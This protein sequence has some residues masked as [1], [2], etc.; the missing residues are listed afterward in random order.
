M[1]QIEQAVSAID[2]TTQQN[3]ALVEAVASI[4]EA[5][6]QQAVGVAQAVSLFD[7]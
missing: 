4:S 6:R 3:S 5:M 2:L 1:T 7:I